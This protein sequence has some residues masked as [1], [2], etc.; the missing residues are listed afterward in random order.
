M[1]A[2]DIPLIFA[3]IIGEPDDEGVA[4]VGAGASTT[5]LTDHCLFFTRY[6]PTNDG[7]RVIMKSH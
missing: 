4:A 5:L 2:I 3:S 6:S 7:S 1:F